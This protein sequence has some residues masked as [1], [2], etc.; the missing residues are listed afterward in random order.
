[1]RHEC[2]ACNGSG[3]CKNDHHWLVNGM[4]DAVTGMGDPC[5][6]CG[7]P[8]SQPGNCSVCGGKGYQDD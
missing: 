5:P 8:P 4:V 3:Q 7:Q 6:A 2:G 1:M